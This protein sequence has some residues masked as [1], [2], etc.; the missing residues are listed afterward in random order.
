MNF[1]RWGVALVDMS[2]CGV[3]LRENKPSQRCM[4]TRVTVG[5]I[6]CECVETFANTC[7]PHIQHDR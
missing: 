1:M 7:T 4:H 3:D 6:V 5:V 2:R